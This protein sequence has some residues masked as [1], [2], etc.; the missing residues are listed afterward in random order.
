ML[1]RGRP[2]LTSARSRALL[3]L[4]WAA[5]VGLLIVLLAQSQART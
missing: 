2:P 4:G 1:S 3:V 5:V